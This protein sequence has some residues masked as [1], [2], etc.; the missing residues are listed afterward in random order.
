MNPITIA[1]AGVL[2][3]VGLVVGRTTTET[4]NANPV[5]TQE[6]TP[7]AT[8]IEESTASPSSTITISPINQETPVPTREPTN[9]VS[10]PLTQ[11][12]NDYVYP[13]STTNQ[14]SPTA[15]TLTS[16]DDVQTI[17]SW[18]EQKVQ[19]FGSKAAAKT[20]SNGKVENKISATKNGESISITIRKTPSS[21]EVTIEVNINKSDSKDS[22]VRI[23]IHNEQKTIES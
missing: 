6:S 23:E 17:T 1:I 11:S 21:S 8:P 18:Y 14:S 16:D 22:N 9:A 12:F 2:F 15:I 3:I 20:N 19:N 10:Q 5:V 13:G 7:S 4:N